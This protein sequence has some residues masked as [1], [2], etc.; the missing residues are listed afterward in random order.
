MNA[1]HL[2]SGRVR[3]DV[4]LMCGEHD[5]FQPPA[6][7]RAQARALTAARSVTTRMFTEAERADQ[8]CQ[9]GNLDLACQVL[10]T[11]LRH[12]RMD[13]TGSGPRPDPSP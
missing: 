2:D 7:T 9:M 6:L 12:G 8:H 3:Q 1:A 5:A 11:W 4:L 13:G 10:T